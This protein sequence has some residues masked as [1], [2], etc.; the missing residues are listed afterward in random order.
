VDSASVVAAFRTYALTLPALTALVG[1]RVVISRADVYGVLPA[2]VL[3]LDGG[4]GRI[5]PRHHLAEIRADFYAETSWADAFA[6]AKALGDAADPQDPVAAMQSYPSPI[7]RITAGAPRQMPQG[8][9]FHV[10]QTFTVLAK[11]I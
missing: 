10:Q 9:Y 3:T 11:E 4:P 2:V 1:Q 5:S 6:V 8:E 7:L